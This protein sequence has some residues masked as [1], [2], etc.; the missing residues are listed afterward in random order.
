MVD[1][2]TN[3]ED[4]HL[5]FKPQKRTVIINEFVLTRIDRR[6]LLWQNE[7][8]VLS[9]MFCAHMRDDASWFLHILCW[10]TM[11]MLN[12]LE[13]SLKQCGAQIHKSH[14]FT[15][16]CKNTSYCALLGRLRLQRME[17]KPISR[18]LQ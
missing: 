7:L 4:K 18:D 11:H 5:P 10:F 3:T 9:R 1:N 12:D 2:F 8:I 6:V 14:I 17:H 13:S 16:Y 15:R